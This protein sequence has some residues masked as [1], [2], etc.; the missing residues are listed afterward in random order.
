M[1]VKV[2]PGMCDAC[3]TCE[4]LCPEVFELGDDDKAHVIGEYEGHEECVEEAMASCPEEAISI[5][6]DNC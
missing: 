6:E 4:E 2:D 1:C 5:D 3:G